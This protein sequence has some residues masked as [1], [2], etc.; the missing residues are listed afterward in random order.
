MRDHWVGI[1]SA[2]SRESYTRSINSLMNGYEDFCHFLKAGRPATVRYH[3]LEL[4]RS[5]TT[6]RSAWRRTGETTP[7]LAPDAVDCRY[8]AQFV[9]LYRHSHYSAPAAI[10]VRSTTEGIWTRHS[11]R[12]CAGA[13]D[14]IT[15]IG[16]AYPV[17]CNTWVI[18]IRQT[19]KYRKWFA[20]LRDMAAKA[21]IDFGP[22]YRVY[23]VQKGDTI[24]MLRCAGDKVTQE[25]GILKAH[26][27]AERN[28]WDR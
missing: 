28:V 7:Y 12:A 21:R 17:G 15:H 19:A 23:F 5:H 6:L 27:L 3:C 2:I 18:E 25:N 16:F 1:G 8:M 20:G 13:H 14:R 11:A 26:A 24:I 22:G 4:E 9:H 10:L